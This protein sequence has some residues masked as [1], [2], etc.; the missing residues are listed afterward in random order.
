MAPVGPDRLAAET[1]SRVRE[2]RWGVARQVGVA[3]TRRG[4]PSCSP[5]DQDRVD[6]SPNLDATRIHT[7]A[8]RVTP[9]PTSDA[10]PFRTPNGVPNMLPSSPPLVA[11]AIANEKRPT[12]RTLSMRIRPMMAS[13]TNAH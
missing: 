3:V 13:P 4:R 9:Y 8:E 10:Q 7:L 11:L 2:R 1:G 12:T 5:R 6:R